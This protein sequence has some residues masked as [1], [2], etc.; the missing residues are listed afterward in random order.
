MSSDILTYVIYRNKA[1]PLH[2]YVVMKDEKVDESKLDKYGEFYAI[3]PMIPLIPS[4]TNL[5]CAEKSDNANL[6]MKNL[7]EI[8]DQ[9]NVKN[10]CTYFIAYQNII[11]NTVPLYLHRLGQIVYPSFDK[12]PPTNNKL[13]NIHHPSPIYVMTKESLKNTPPDDVKF[14]CINSTCI[15]W[16]DD[17]PDIYDVDNT[18]DLLSLSN[19]VLYCNELSDTT[20]QG[21]LSSLLESIQ[22]SKEK[23]NN[24]NG[25]SRMIKKLSPLLIGI[26]IGIL[27][28]FLILFIYFVYRMNIGNNRS[29]SSGSG[30]SSAIA[31][32]Y[33]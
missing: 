18:S 30:Y 9:F 21:K 27:T 26:F 10:N 16:V 11:P 7:I 33:R 22:S 32:R 25:I 13:W 2:S 17:I 19:C 8:T 1:H 29:S 3:N 20:S 4:L 24:K 5:Y 14:K 23:G 31:K 12:N 15:P 28:M 6:Y